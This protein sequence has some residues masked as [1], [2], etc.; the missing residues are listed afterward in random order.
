VKITVALS[1]K[2]AY[3]KISIGELKMNTFN[4]QISEDQL[5]LIKSALQKDSS[6]SES[7]E[8]I[9]GMIQD[10]LESKDSEITHGICY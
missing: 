8:L 9:I 6:Y 7:E 10:I 2:R 4:I 3:D 1:S 5:N